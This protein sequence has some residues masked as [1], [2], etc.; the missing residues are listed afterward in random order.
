MT[1]LCYQNKR[2]GNRMVGSHRASDC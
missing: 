2:D 1:V